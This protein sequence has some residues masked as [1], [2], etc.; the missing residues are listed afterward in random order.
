MSKM[1]CIIQTIC[2][3]S[4]QIIHANGEVR[5]D[6][7]DHKGIFKQDKNIYSHKLN[8]IKRIIADK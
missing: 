4:G 6:Q 5:M 1:N 7:L 8:V 3:G 2:I